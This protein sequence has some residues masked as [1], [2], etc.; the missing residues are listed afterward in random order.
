MSRSPGS[1]AA[2]ASER[3]YLRAAQ[4][5]ALAWSG[6]HATGQN[7]RRPRAAGG[8]QHVRTIK[9][10][11]ATAD[12]SAPAVDDDRCGGR[13]QPAAAAVRG[14]RRGGSH[15][16]L[17]RDL[18]QGPTAGR[19]RQPRRSVGVP[20]R[21]HDRRAGAGATGE[22]RQ[23]FL[24]GTRSFAPL[25]VR[26]QRDRRLPGPK[27]RLGRGLRDR[28]EQR[29]AHPAQPS[30][31]G[32]PDPGAPHHRSGREIP[33][34]RELHGRQLR[35]PADRG[36][37][38]AGAGQQRGRGARLRPEQAAPGGATSAY[39]DVPIPPANTSLPPISASTR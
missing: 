29:H 17:C 9:Q 13:R 33:G 25:S 39:R 37:R 6:T 7:G 27:G 5:N 22:E 32:R 23:S 38:A 30:I 35:G 26:H 24:C 12:L 36:G 18:Y 4:A 20:L 14:A 1:I 31:G 19:P 2:P 15:V 3:R 28:P 21:S 34:R 16:R 11:D 10:R 8:N